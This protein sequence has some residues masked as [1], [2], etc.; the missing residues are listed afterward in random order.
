M[1]VAVMTVVVIASAAL[2]AGAGSSDLSEGIKLKAD[3]KVIDIKVGHLVPCVLDWNADGNKDL[4]VGQFSGG[5]IRLYLF[6]GYVVV[7]K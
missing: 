7:A 4:V 2:L 3:G 5:K 6:T 1:K